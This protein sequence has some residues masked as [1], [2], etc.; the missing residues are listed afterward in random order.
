MAILGETKEAFNGAFIFFF[1]SSIFQFVCVFFGFLFGV[2]GLF[3]FLFGWGF[4]FFFFFFFL[5]S[6]YPAEAQQSE[7]QISWNRNIWIWF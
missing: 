3:L 2:F 1:H 7:V 4:L 5:V 6:T